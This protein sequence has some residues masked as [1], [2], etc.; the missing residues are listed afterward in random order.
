MPTIIIND[1]SYSATMLPEKFWAVGNVG[2]FGTSG[3]TVRRP[4]T[5][6]PAPPETA[7]APTSSL[8]EEGATAASVENEDTD[9]Q[10]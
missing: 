3:P 4:D 9:M 7:A 6:G 5:N 8:T 10:Q 2:K 1:V